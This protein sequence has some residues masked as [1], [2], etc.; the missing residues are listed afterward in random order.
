MV[1]DFST[2]VN[3]QGEDIVW[4]WPVYGYRIEC[5]MIGSMIAQGQMTLYYED[6]I[7]GEQ[8][9]PQVATYGFWCF[10]QGDITQLT[11]VPGSG[12]WFDCHGPGDPP[13]TTPPDV[14]IQPTG[15]IPVI[16]HR[17]PWLN[18]DEIKRVI[19]HLT[20]VCDDAWMFDG[21]PH[22][23]PGPPG[24]LWVSRP[25]Y[26]GSC[27]AA[28]GVETEP[29]YAITW[30][31][32]IGLTGLWQWKVYMTPPDGADELNNHA[33]FWEAGIYYYDQEAEP[34]DIWVPIGIPWHY[35]QGQHVAVAI[36]NSDAQ[37]MPCLTYMDAF[38]L[39]Y[40]GPSDDGGA[41][42][43]VSLSGGGMQRVR[44]TPNPAMSIA[45]ISYT[46]LS[47]TRAGIVVYDV[48]GR[49]VARLDQ[50][51]QQPGCRTASVPVSG[52]KAGAYLA[53]VSV[54]GVSATCRF[55]VCR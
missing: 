39:E 7:Y 47:P 32:R 46:V 34:H 22:R 27:W 20:I 42:T 51:V 25:G 44:V 8:H 55:V 10:V 31:P 19:D 45:R 24:D 41:S 23:P 21:Y 40:L 5:E 49:A 29:V 54:D 2:E 35:S 52:L 28:P 16:R 17:N 14:A 26:G 1:I 36:Q 38:R 43:P 53:R 33:A 3:E 13:I 18:Y 48:A 6:H 9:A 37:G 4:D 12:E 11:P 15:R 30:R 50:G